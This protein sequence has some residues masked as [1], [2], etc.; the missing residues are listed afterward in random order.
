MIPVSSGSSSGRILVVRGGAVGD[1]ILTLPVLT[2]L[3][4]HFPGNRIE[5]LGYPQ[6]AGLAVE[7]G[8]AD[9]ARG[10]DSRP[11]AG[12]FARGGDL[13]PG[14]SAYFAE[15]HLVVSYLYDPDLIFR[16]NLA[17]VSKAGFIQ[18]PHRP[19][20]SIA[21]HASA[22]LLRPLEQLAVFDSDPVPRL[23]RLPVHE[24]PR[25][26]AIHPGS[27]SDRKN[28]PEARWEELLVR[29][30]DQENLRFLLVGGEA[31]GKRL[32]RLARVIPSGRCE[33]LRSQ[34]LTE[35][36]H[37]LSACIG[38]LGHDSGITHLAAAIGLPGVILWGPSQVAIWR[39]LQERMDLIEA[40]D[41]LGDLPVARVIEVVSPRIQ[42]WFGAR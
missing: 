35:V 31:E 29:L 15:F 34:P 22:Q 14:L 37:R 8:L 40:G 21:D 33:V 19:D 12:F 26:L 9:A 38:F 3:R 23:P 36:A 2:A 20:E 11:L 13:D 7:A 1:F 18:G 17:R 42:S 6:V 5:V 4:T 41:H 30:A 10:I 32:E 27:G 24:G 39:P 16:T 28:W 25:P